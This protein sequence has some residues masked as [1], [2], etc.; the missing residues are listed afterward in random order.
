[1]S[2]SNHGPKP[3]TAIARF[4]TFRLSRSDYLA[5]DRRH[6][7]VALASTWVVGMGR[8]WDDPKAGFLQ[9]LGIGSVLYACILAAVLWVIVAPL[10]PLDWTYGR[11]LTLVAST[12]PPGSLYA[13]P[14]EK[15]FDMHTAGQIN[16][17]FLAIV[18]LWRVSLLIHFLIRFPLIG[19]IR[20]VI[21]AL[22]PVSA[23]VTALT[24]LN[25][26][27]VVFDFMSGLAE[28]DRTAHDAAYGVLVGLT[29]ISWTV[30]PLVALGYLAAVL[31]AR[32][33][34]PWQ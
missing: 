2:E 29:F 7:Q 21:C 20:A 8:W 27:R 1:M 31:T 33:T 4:L 32:R 10:K 14:V 26:H 30:F 3:A 34:R 9:H 17:W 28:H 15:F 11:T 23:I 18:A 22:L 13:I 25:L 12:A 16:L 5:L 6:L 19:W 24:A